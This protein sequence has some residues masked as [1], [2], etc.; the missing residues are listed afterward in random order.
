MKEQQQDALAALDVIQEIH[1]EMKAVR[2]Q[3]PYA[4]LFTQTKY[5]KSR[6]SRHIA[7]QFRDNPAISTFVS[8]IDERD[9]YSAIFTTG[10]SVRALNPET[11]NNLDKAIANVH[12]FAAEV[13]TK[14]KALRDEQAREVA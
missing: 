8:E 14:L 9:A 13:I 6:T 10:G 11:V 3:I 5:V 4:A 12:A 1:R 7:G 2:R